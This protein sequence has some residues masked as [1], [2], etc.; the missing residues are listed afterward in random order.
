MCLKNI[1]SLKTCSYVKEMSESKVIFSPLSQL[2]KQNIA[3][4]WFVILY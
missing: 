1:L 4:E 3:F 2:I